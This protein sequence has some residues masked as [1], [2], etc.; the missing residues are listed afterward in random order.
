MSYDTYHLI[1]VIGAILAGLMLVLAVTL[2]FYDR[3]PRVIGDLTGS[4]A[5]KAIE[6]IRQQN[7]KSGNKVHKTSTVNRDRGKITSKMTP[8]GRLAQ[9]QTGEVG[10][11]KTEKITTAKLNQNS[12]E[13][14]PLETA[15]AT[16]ILDQPAEATTILDQP[17][18][19]T[20]ILNQPAEATTILNQPAE[21]AT[22]PH[23]NGDETMLL[24]PD[25]WAATVAASAAPPAPAPA[26]ATPP[27]GGAF[28]IEYELTF[29]HSD[30]LIA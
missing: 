26:P 4:T 24:T 28:V 18:E 13:T 27:V 29:I 21:A 23:G 6:D 9:K 25:H 10:A 12:Q 20:T 14:V 7:A 2:F 16:T 15:E 30:E 17:A 8:S 19:A 3:I 22:L 5:K 11:I 1:F